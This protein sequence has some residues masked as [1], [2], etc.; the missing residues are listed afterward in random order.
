M[1]SYNMNILMF[2]LL[3]IILVIVFNNFVFK[4]NEGFFAYDADRYGWQNQ[5]LTDLQAV[6]YL[7][8]NPGLVTSFLGPYWTKLMKTEGMSGILGTAKWHWKERGFKEIGTDDEK[9]S[10]FTCLTDNEAKCYLENNPAL[11]KAFGLTDQLKDDPNASVANGANASWIGETSTHGK[12]TPLAKAKIHWK[13]HGSKEVGTT[14]QKVSPFKCDS[15]PVRNN[16]KYYVYTLGSC[17]AG[18]VEDFKWPNRKNWCSDNKIQYTEDGFNSR[19]VKNGSLGENTNP[20][21][22]EAQFNDIVSI[23]GKSGRYIKDFYTIKEREDFKK[24]SESLTKND[25][26]EMLSNSETKLKIAL[27]GNEK[28]K[29]ECVDSNNTK[30]SCPWD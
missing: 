8:N 25:L 16:N 17:T 12:K 20:S 30:T 19:F 18:G 5:R 1:K 27:T 3:I 23:Y 22:K 9:I 4:S 29:F 2:I 28:G 26:K 10:P 14:K 11:V 15:L 21:Y 6:C 7:E 13:N 24:K